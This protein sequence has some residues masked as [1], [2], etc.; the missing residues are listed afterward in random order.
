MGNSEFAGLDYCLESCDLV[1]VLLFCT[2]NNVLRVLTWIFMG[3]GREGG[4]K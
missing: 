2:S 3:G 1:L 4:N